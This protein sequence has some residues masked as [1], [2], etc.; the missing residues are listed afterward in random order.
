LLLLLWQSRQSGF[1]IAQLQRGCD[2][3][4]DGQDRGDILDRDTDAFRQ[5][6]RTSL[7][8]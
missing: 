1:E 6:R 4:L 8:C 7:T 2:V 3:G 5:G